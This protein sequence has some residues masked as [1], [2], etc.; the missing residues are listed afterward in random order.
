M[1]VSATEA[2]P[3]FA[4]KRLLYVTVTKTPNHV[5]YDDTGRYPLYR[6]STITS[7][8]YWLKLRK[9]PMKS[10]PKQTLIMLEKIL[11]MHA[12]NSTSNWAGNINHC[13]VFSVTGRGEWTS[14]S[15]W[16]FHYLLVVKT[17]RGNEA[18]FPYLWPKYTHGPW[19]T[20]H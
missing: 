1:R 9:L 20:E 11:D 17:A 16:M 13:L 7:L 5:V 4:C 2:A 3:L 14:D 15:K 8:R 18:I 19:S 12:F 10:F 6:E